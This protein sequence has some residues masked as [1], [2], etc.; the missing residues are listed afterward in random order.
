[1]MVEQFGAGYVI[2]IFSL[3]SFII[4][5]LI[6]SKMETP[7]KNDLHNLNSFLRNPT[8]KVRVKQIK[9]RTKQKHSD[10]TDAARYQMGLAAN[11]ANVNG[12]SKSVW[13]D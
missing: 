3:L 6:S 10:L 4:G 13:H 12:K 8:L 9:T 11:A 2:T 1:M 7:H 5:F